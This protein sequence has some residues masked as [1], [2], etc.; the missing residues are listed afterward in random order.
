MEILVIFHHFW[1]LR[2]PMCVVS[3]LILFILVLEWILELFAVIYL[4]IYVV[5]RFLGLPP[6]GVTGNY[7]LLEC[8]GWFGR[9]ALG[10]E[11]TVNQAGVLGF[12]FR[13]CMLIILYIWFQS[14]LT[15]IDVN[16][17]LGPNLHCRR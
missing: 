2:T 4:K 17:I 16:F 1:I 11:D 15:V 8:I 9:L 12:P 3:F 13:V 10:E 5:V 14:C 6:T 7:T